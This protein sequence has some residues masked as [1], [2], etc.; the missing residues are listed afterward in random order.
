MLL[1]IAGIVLLFAHVW[2]I[3]QYLTSYREKEGKAM[4]LAAQAVSYKNS[5]SNA[6]LIAEEVA[7]VD[8][9]EPEP[10]TFGDEQSKLL[11]FLKSSA[12][13]IGFTPVKPQLTEMTNTGDKYLR[14]KIQIQ[15]TATEDQI[16][17]WLVDIHQPTEFRAVTQIVMRPTAKVDD[18]G[19]IICTL[20][21]EQWLIASNSD[22][23]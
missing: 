3:K 20:T 12:T 8:K 10:S 13:S 15:A 5:S 14:T 23:L 18:D 16:Y 17:K 21:A 9:H 6:V 1:L 22:S 4:A 2:G 11:E 19:L 7:W